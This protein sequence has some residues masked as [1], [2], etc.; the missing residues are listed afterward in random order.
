M[1][2]ATKRIKHQ[3]TFVEEDKKSLSDVRPRQPS[4]EFE[5]W[6]RTIESVNVREELAKLTDEFNAAAKLG[7][8][9]TSGLVEIQKCFAKLKPQTKTGP[10]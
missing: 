7:P 3:N 9:E 2:S 10:A 1:A 8:K 6:E 4:P 5:A